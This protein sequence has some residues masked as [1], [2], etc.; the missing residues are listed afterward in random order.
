MADDGSFPN[1][2]Q[3]VENANPVSVA[4]ET[5]ENEEQ[6]SRLPPS[7]MSFDCVIRSP[8]TIEADVIQDNAAVSVPVTPR[9]I[10]PA[11]HLQQARVKASPI[12]EIAK[13][14]GR[15]NTKNS[16][17]RCQAK[18]LTVQKLE[19]IK[20]MNMRNQAKFERERRSRMLAE[21]KLMKEELEAAKLNIADIEMGEDDEGEID[22]DLYIQVIREELDKKLMKEI[23]GKIGPKVQENPE[24]F[25]KK[26]KLDDQA[27][28]SK[29]PRKNE[30]TSNP[31]TPSPTLTTIPAPEKS[32]IDTVPLLRELNGHLAKCRMRMRAEEIMDVRSWIEKGFDAGTRTLLQ[33]RYI[34]DAEAFWEDKYQEEG[35]NDNLKSIVKE[36]DTVEKLHTLRVHFGRI[37]GDEMIFV[38]KCDKFSQEE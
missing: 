16:M 12:I 31:P 3:E 5:P 10:D 6:D 15:F 37:L 29:A 11:N 24:H 21:A 23:A 36:Y 7:N 8:S 2:D 9:A 32:W 26:R 1:R 18:K 34:D 19:M 13:Q 35:L 28:L 17:K 30:P 27:E 38:Y 22:N 4:P 14:I 20:Y 25:S 33:H